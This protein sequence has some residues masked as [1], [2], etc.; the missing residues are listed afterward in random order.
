MPRTASRISVLFLALLC[1]CNKATDVKRDCVYAGK[2]YAQGDTF[3]STDGCNTCSCGADGQVAC[4]LRACLDGGFDAGS[5]PA[6]SWY[7]TCG[8]PVCGPQFDGPTG[9]PLCTTETVGAPCTQK[10]KL[11]D[12]SLG[13]AVNLVCTDSDPTMQPGGCPI[14]RARYKNHVHYLDDGELS[15]LAQ[16]LLATPLARFRY[17]GD[18]SQTDQTGFLIEDVAPSPSVSGDHVNLYGYTSMTVAALKVQAQQMQALEREVLQMRGRLLE[19]EQRCRVG[20]S[21]DPRPRIQLPSLKA[22]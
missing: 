10:D 21:L 3:P 14:S 13:C 15:E 17:K 9:Q 16:E 7:R 22:P 18:I 4:T 5:G 20:K 11:C 19:L 8:A 1:A 12:P 6:L 2:Q